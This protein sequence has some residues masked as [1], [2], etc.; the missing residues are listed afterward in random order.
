M[1]SGF[2][3][4]GHWSSWGRISQWEG[5]SLAGRYQL[6]GYRRPMESGRSGRGTTPIASIALNLA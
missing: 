6:E 3:K 4:S 2:G 5:R 1:A